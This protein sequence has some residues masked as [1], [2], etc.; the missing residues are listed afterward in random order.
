MREQVTVQGLMANQERGFAICSR[1]SSTVLFEAEEGNKFNWP[2][3][4]G[5]YRGCICC[6]I[7]VTWVFL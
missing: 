2:S 4:Q 6:A 1:Y 7:T 3:L 5:S